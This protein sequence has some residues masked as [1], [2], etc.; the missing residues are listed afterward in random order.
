MSV[1]TAGDVFAAGT[2]FH[3]NGGFVDE[4]ARMRSDDVNSKDSICDLVG[5]NFYESVGVSGGTSAAVRGEIETAGSVLNSGLPE[6]VLIGAR[7]DNFRLCVNH[8]RN[9]AVV[10][11]TV[12]CHHPFDTGNAF[13]FGLVSQ[14]GATDHVTHSVD[15]RCGRLVTGVDLDEATFPS[16]NVSPCFSKIFFASVATC[17]STPGRMRGRYFITKPCFKQRSQFYR[18]PAACQ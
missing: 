4:F 14:H 17:S 15:S 5:K 2:E 12:T 9:C 6:S 3:R 1:A 8:S 11:V 10:D 7:G 16:L 13:F 18:P